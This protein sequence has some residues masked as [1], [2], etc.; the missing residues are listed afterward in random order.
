MEGIVDD[1]SHHCIPFIL[2]RLQIHR[3]LYANAENAPPLF[4]GLNA[5]QGAGKTVL[6]RWETWESLG[7]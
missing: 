7:L 6:V 2:E 3:Q 4:L 1:K 5:V